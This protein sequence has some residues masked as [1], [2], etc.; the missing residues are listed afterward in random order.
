MTEYPQLQHT[1]IDTVDV[2]GLADFYRELLG[3]R[4]RPGD[5]APSEGPDDADWLV[6]EDAGGVVRLAFQEVEELTRTTWPA[7]DVP[8]QM[9]LDTT[10]TDRAEL[11]RQRGRA[12]ALGATLILD[13]SDDQDE[14][15]YVFADPSGHPFCLFVG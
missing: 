7:N 1:V 4:Y 6:L 3:Y 15:L 10:V 2:R 12:E 11:E 9:H 14:P 13:R 5:E 8:M